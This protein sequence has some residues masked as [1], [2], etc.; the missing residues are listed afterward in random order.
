MPLATEITLQETM[1]KLEHVLLAPVVSGELQNWV[2]NVQQAAATFAMDF[3]TYVHTI[4]HVQYEQIVS[5]DPEL[6]SAVQ[7]LVQEDQ[8]LLGDLAQFHEDLHALSERA[9]RVDKHESKVEEQRKRLEEAGIDLIVRI[10]K[11]QAAAGTW[12]T[13]A[14]YRDRGVKD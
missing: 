8:K 7:L 12:L 3:T 1:G 5:T 4:L 9:E 2:R 13:E 14:H 6:D 11:Q 10:K